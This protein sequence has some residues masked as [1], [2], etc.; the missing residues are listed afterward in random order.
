MPRRTIASLLLFFLTSPFASARKVQIGVLGLFHP[1]QITLSVTNKEALLLGADTNVFVLEPGPGP[2]TARIQIAGNMLL[3]EVGDRVVRVTEIHAAGRDSR[4]ATFV[5][6]VAGK[7]SRQYR[8]TLAVKAIEG[9]IVPVVTME[10]ETAVGSVVAA[11][12]APDA[13][14]EALKAQAVVTRSYFTAGK[15]RH[16][17]FDFCDL[18]HCQFLRDPPNPESPAGVASSATRGLVV[19]YKE[20]P[21]AA[22]FTRS[23]GGRTRTP[24]QLGIPGGGYPYF[25]VR[26]DYCYKNPSRWTRRISAPDAARLLGK[27]EA[28]RLAVDR[29]LGWN[30][31]PSNTFAA[32]TEEG[33]VILE[34]VGQGHG[35]GFCQ[36]GAKAMAEAGAGF[37]EIISHYFPNTTVTSLEPQGPS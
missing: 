18:T 25:S 23:C 15:G 16:H 37:R 13:S 4:A 1:R 3:L 35:I 9:V 28:G 14:L 2:S 11:E 27:G 12:S 5:L 33:E 29:L 10:L 7:I 17:D 32:R 21:V 19:T 22:M 36:R 34:G 8:G 24:A 6:G 20:K 26:C 30:A 31:V